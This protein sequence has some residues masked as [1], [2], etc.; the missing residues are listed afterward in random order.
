MRTKAWGWVVVALLAGCGGDA[1]EKQV[2]D[3][4]VGPA[5][6]PGA[7]DLLAADAGKTDGSVG[8]ADVLAATDTPAPDLAPGLT[9]ARLE[10]DSPTEVSPPETGPAERPLTDL[11]RDLATIE[12]SLRDVVGSPS[13]A[14]AI[15]VPGTVEAG[16]EAA[17]VDFAAPSD[18]PTEVGGLDAP[19][20]DGAQDAAVDATAPANYT[21]R[22]D[23]DCCIV[24]DTCRE[25]AYLYSK[26]PGATGQPSISG[27]T[28]C[29]PCIPPAVQVRCDL[30]QCVGEKV[31]A[32][33]FGP[34]RQDHCGPVTMPDAGAILPYQTGYAG[35]QQ[36]SWGC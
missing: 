36:T 7:R 28:M 15:E 10:P 3:S 29:V 1:D 11:A 27:G 25:V 2:K 14:F 16:T 22:D 34:I 13:E 19:G 6:V 21:C 8:P 20:L 32:D 23:S 17:S 35:A 26:A 31:S 12:T 30:G 5:D 18:A 24:I 9:D 33:Y 4:S